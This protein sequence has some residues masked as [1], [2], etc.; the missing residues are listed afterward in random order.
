MS[1]GDY[2]VA[3][4]RNRV[5]IRNEDQ[6]DWLGDDSVSAQLNES[7]IV[8]E[9]GVQCR[10]SVLLELRDLAD[11]AF[12]IR[13][14]GFDGASEAIDAG[15]ASE[16]SVRRK[17]VGESPVQ[18]YQ[19]V[20]GGLSEVQSLYVCCRD[21]RCICRIARQTKSSL[22]DRCGTG[23]VPILILGRGEAKCLKARESLLA[24]RLQTVG[25]G[26][27]PLEI[28]AVGFDGARCAGRR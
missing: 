18:E 23:E 12:Q 6:M 7:A 5:A 3:W 17:V 19:R 26:Y 10:E 8:D 24:Q 20:P 28:R 4:V 22:G 9:C 16:S 13:R 1:A 21:T 11:A 15:S 25:P 2:E 27:L 14:P